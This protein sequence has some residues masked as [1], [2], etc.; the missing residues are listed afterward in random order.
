MST[1]REVTTIVQSWL[2]DGVRTLPD[3][4]LDDVL[5]QLPQTRQRR[6][7]YARRTFDMTTMFKAALAAAAVFAIAITLVSLNGNGAVGGLSPTPSLTATATPTAA[8]TQT[9]TPVPTAEPAAGPIELPPPGDLEPGSYF[10]DVQPTAFD[11]AGM[12]VENP[13]LYRATFT[14]PAGLQ[15]NGWAVTKHGVQPPEG[16]AFAAWTIARIN[17]DPCHP[18]PEAA[19]DVSQL[20]GPDDL[21]AALSDHWTATDPFSPTSPTAEVLTDG[22]IGDLGARH[23]RLMAPDDLDFLTCGNSRYIV[24]EI[25]DTSPR[26]LQGAGQTLDLWIVDVDGA[27][28]PGGLVVFE[29]SSFPATTDADLQDLDEIISSIAIEPVSP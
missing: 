12:P 28:A 14:V 24:W 25:E 26:F 3:R 20:S 29:G 18:T 9:P 11:D 4:V 23:V 7:W 17:P 15:S 21:A 8:P 19:V 13:P 10:M 6:A 16:M 22:T 5:A 2:E 27:D 1:D